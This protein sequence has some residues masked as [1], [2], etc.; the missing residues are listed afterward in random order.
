M[1]RPQVESGAATHAVGREA[2]YGLLR[3]LEENRYNV[4]TRRTVLGAKDWWLMLKRA[5]LK[6]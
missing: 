5:W 2:G 4:F 6:K 1:C 3:K